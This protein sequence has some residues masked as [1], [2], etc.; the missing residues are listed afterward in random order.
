MILSGGTTTLGVYDFKAGL[1]EFGKVD[2]WSAVSGGHPLNK[3]VMLSNGEIVQSTIPANTNNPNTNITGWK[4]EKGNFV[5]TPSLLSSISNPTDGERAYVASLQK[6]YTYRVG[7]TSIENGVTVVGDWEMDVQDAYYASWFATPLTQSDQSVSIQVGYDYAVSVKRP[8]IIDDHFYVDPSNPTKTSLFVRS[9]STIIFSKGV[10]KVQQ[11]ATSATNYDIVRIQ[12]IEN[13][14]IFDPELIGDKDVHTG[15]SGEWGYGLTVYQCSNGYIRSPN[16][17][18]TWGDGIYIGKQWGLMNDNVPTNIVIDYA[19]INGAGRNGIS[20]TSGD[21]VRIVNPHIKNTSGKSPQAGID[22]EPE[23]YTLAPSVVQARLNNCVIVNPVIENC[24]LGIANYFFH[25]NATYELHVQGITKITNCDQPLVACAGGSSNTG[26]VLYDRIDIK[27]PTGN[28]IIQN[29]WHKS[30]N[31]KFT[32]NELNTDRNLPIVMTLNGEFPTKVLGNFEIKNISSTDSGRMGYYVPPAI[33][34]YTDNS[35]YLFSN[36][37]RENAYIDNSSNNILGSDFNLEST[38]F[39]N[40]FSSG[41][42]IYPNIIW[43]N[44][45]IDTAGT[46]QIFL[47]TVNDFRILKIGLNS[48]TAVIGE[49]CNISG[50]N[51][52]ID[53]VAKTQAHTKTLGGW[54][55]FQNKSGGRTRIIDSYGTWSFS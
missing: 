16:I 27:N 14:L 8:Y 6:W 34:G 21:N 4:F 22:I 1:D 37:D 19:T 9:N 15:S 11:L 28:T 38:G 41:T 45:S 30:G 54:I 51:L 49:G 36:I 31:F 17:S 40:G 10:G 47:G 46:T 5:A 52:F 42:T 12:D 24:P 23:Y 20:L 50:L 48:D 32:A 43:Q 44:P 33:S 53:G 35:R 25:S 13:F 3:R 26:Y 2:Y 18:N 39:H 7:N 55:K 29:A